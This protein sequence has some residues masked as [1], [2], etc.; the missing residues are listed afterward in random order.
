MTH[1]SFS[2][3]LQRYLVFRSKKNAWIA[4]KT[5]PIYKTLRSGELDVGM[6]A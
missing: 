5:N 4:A 1:Q 6:L 3:F 2:Q